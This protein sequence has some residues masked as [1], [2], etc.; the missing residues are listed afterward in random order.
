MTLPLKGLVSSVAFYDLHLTQFS[1][2]TLNQASQGISSLVIK[3]V[4]IQFDLLCL[5]V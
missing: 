1:V 3:S 2:M 4:N 5:P